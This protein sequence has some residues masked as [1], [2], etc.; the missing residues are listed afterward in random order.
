[1]I[2]LVL[3]AF[4]G[5][6]ELAEWRRVP[7]SELLAVTGEALDAREVLA[8]GRLRDP[9]AL[10]AL[11][12]AL[13]DADLAPTAAFAL[14]LTPGSAPAIRR[15][16]A[17]TAPRTSRDL[18]G[19]R[20]L[21]WQLVEA[22]GRQGDAS[23]RPLLEGLLTAPWP[24]DEA[25]A[26]AL[27][28]LHRGRHD[29][30]AAVP[31]LVR[32]L[33]AE[34]PRTGIAAA[35]ALVR[36]G[37]RGLPEPTLAHLAVLARQLPTEEGRASLVKAL[38]P[39]LGADDRSRLLTLAWSDRPLVRAAVLTAVTSG[40]VEGAEAWAREALV[41]AHPWVL[42]AAVDA[43]ASLG[44]KDALTDLARRHA[45]APHVLG[46]VDA[47]LEVRA[48]PDAPWPVRAATLAGSP[49]AELEALALAPNE[50]AG[51]RTAA[52]SALMEREND[53]A[54]W[55]RLLASPDEG[56]R[57][58]AIGELPERPK[59]ETVEELV[60]TLRVERDI[61]VT[62]AGLEKLLAWR[63][64]SRTAVVR[65]RY[66][67]SV[68][69][70]TAKSTHP[71][72]REAALELAAALG[73]EV[74]PVA[75]EATVRELILPDGT[76]TTT[77][78]ELPEP[79]EVRRYRA[80]RLH[81]TRGTVTLALDPGIAPLAV[82]DFVSLA[83]SGFYSGLLWHRVVPGFVAQTGC[84]RG[85]GWGGPGWEIVDEVSDRAYLPG[86]VGFA[87]SDRDSAGSQFFVA[88]GPARFLDGDYTW[89]GRVTEG[90]DVVR[91]LGVGD[92]LDAVELL[93]DTE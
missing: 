21:R 66:L 54:L 60:V 7:V 14:G 48:L 2:T 40:P 33:E 82:H 47:A 58:A 49:T 16:L 83:R 70:R 65:S 87:R 75:H 43:A 37:V 52:V 41:E 34:D 10:P 85:D 27:L 55:V 86:A 63:K 88:T 42:P 69:K 35:Q 4:A 8:L 20:D 15:A 51:V 1:M 3:A 13:A 6:V 28:R 93:L 59:P 11:E 36:M 44:L 92:T 91:A 31:A 68:L 26:R 19:E 89:F 61:S 24:D 73:L 84:P 23:D 74:P 80:A 64:A 79:A 56:V 46:L 50:P 22:L 76:V 30:L 38:A 67:D 5:E 12:R 32:A 57:A 62:R 39:V 71:P 18:L 25:A 77:T 81:T 9:A 78:G 17:R 29:V 72:V 90:L 53:P 45:D